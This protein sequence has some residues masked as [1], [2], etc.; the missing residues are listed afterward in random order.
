MLAGK[1]TKAIYNGMAEMR[2][3]YEPGQ[4]MSNSLLVEVF[5]VDHAAE[6]ECMG[7]VGVIGTPAREKTQRPT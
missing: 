4:L 6:P 7:N 3:S 1:K 5:E 2:H